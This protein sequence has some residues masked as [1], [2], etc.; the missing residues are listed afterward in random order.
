MYNFSWLTIMHIYRENNQQADFLSKKAL[1]L[2]PGFEFF[3]K[4]LDGMIIDHGNF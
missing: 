4:Y 1:V 2:D 3:T